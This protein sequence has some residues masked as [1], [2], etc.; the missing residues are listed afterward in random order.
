M[1]SVNSPD[2]AGLESAVEAPSPE[3]P[4]G[5]RRKS[6]PLVRAMRP[7]QW[8]KNLLVFAPAV[9]HHAVFD[10]RLVGLS[11]L[12][13]VLFC[14]TTSAIYILN[15]VLDLESDRRH[16]VKRFRPFAAGEIRVQT[17]Y[18]AAALFLVGAGLSALVFLNWEF[19]AVLLTYVVV[20]FAYSLR[21]KQKVMIDVIILAGFYTL[22]IIAGGAATQLVPSE[23]LLALAMF[24]FLS[25]AFVKRFDE[26]ARLRDEG[27]LQTDRRGYQVV[28]LELLQ[29]MGL[30]CGMMAVLVLALY[31]NSDQVLT[32]YTHPRV[33]WLACPLL[34]FWIGRIWIWA[35]RGAIQEDPL[36]FAIKDRAS[37]AVLVLMAIVGM[38]S[39]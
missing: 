24:L 22:R 39:I 13:F 32:I 36:L 5:A 31:I 34:L 14:T 19:F 35:R 28:D 18:T 11:T 16:P 3:C 10:V 6:W 23:W 1:E 7:H 2:S 9:F 38:V 27:R 37:W 4:P 30:S 17:G 33:L 8:V 29:T 15:D 21:L 26:L 12:A 25:L 20:N